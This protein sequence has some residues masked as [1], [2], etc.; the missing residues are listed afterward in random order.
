VI[1]STPYRAIAGDEFFPPRQR[2]ESS[3]SR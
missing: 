2:G 1:R 3:P